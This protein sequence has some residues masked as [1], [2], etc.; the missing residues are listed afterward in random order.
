MARFPIGQP[1]AMSTTV[2]V[3]GVLTDPG[4][5]SAKLY[6][7]GVGLTQTYASPVRDSVGRFHQDIP[8]ADLPVVAHYRLV[9]TTT[10]T[11]AGVVEQSFDTFDPI[12]GADI[13]PSRPRV[14]KYIPARTI[15]ADQS[16]DLPTNDF[17]PLTTPTADQADDHIAAAVSWVAARVGTVA[18]ALYG[19]AAEVAAIRAAGM[20]ELSYPVRDADINTAEQLLAQAELW[21]TALVE[22]NEDVDVSDPGGGPGHVLSAWIFPSPEPW[23]DVLVWG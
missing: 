16:S 18:P 5:I 21:L 10:G 4:G 20:I 23:G 7:D 22:A 19:Q 3:A 9:W 2:A 6:R 1:V 12:L 11:A 15:P 17:G 13:Y 8:A 14:A